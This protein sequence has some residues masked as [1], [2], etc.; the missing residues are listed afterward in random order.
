MYVC[1]GQFS[2]I[3]YT[4]GPVFPCCIQ[5]LPDFGDGCAFVI[6]APMHYYRGGLYPAGSV[7]WLCHLVSPT[8]VG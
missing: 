8:L 4:Y 3:W 1:Y 7:E 5:N 2:N 6:F